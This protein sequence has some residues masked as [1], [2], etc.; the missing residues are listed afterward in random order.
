MRLIRLA[1]VL[2]LLGIPSAAFAA[3]DVTHDYRV[4]RSARGIL[5]VQIDFPAAILDVQNTPG[6]QLE[7]FGT[8]SRQWEEAAEKDRAQE[9]VNNSGAQIAVKGTR[10]IVSRAFGPNAQGRSDQGS[11]TRFVVHVR[12][13]R[14]MHLEVRQLAGEVDVAGT[15]ATST[16]SAQR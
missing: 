14:G 4:T 3:Q 5:R 8:V 13:P 15:S 6:D 16:W 7:V 2:L 1:S 10:A 9:I 12:I 11:Q